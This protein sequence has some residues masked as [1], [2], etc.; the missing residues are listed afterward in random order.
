MNTHLL[1]LKL[2]F[3]LIEK[4]G[5]NV[6]NVEKTFYEKA[7][8][9]PKRARKT[10]KVTEFIVDRLKTN[11]SMKYIA[12]RADVSVN[13]ISGLLPQLSVSAQNYQKFSV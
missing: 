11:Q 7:H 4:E 8:F 9:L 5:I 1:D 2:L 12:K 13:T 3:S 10:T 6:N